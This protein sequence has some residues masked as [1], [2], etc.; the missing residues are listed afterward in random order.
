MLFRIFGRSDSVYWSQCDTFSD[1]EKRLKTEEFENF[2]MDGING[3][4]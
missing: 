1:L 2:Q 4:S 3:M